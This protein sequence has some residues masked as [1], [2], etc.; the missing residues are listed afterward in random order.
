MTPAEQIALTAAISFFLT[1][2]FTGV[3]KYRHIAAS[4][5]AAAWFLVA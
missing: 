4:A 3:W 5:D 1:G 2:L